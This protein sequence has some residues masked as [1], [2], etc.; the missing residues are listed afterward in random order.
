MFWLLLSSTCTDLRF[1][2]PSLPQ[3][4]WGFARSWEGTAD[5]NQ[6]KGYSIP[7][8]IMLSNKN[9]EKRGEREVIH[10][11]SICLVKVTVVHADALQYR[12]WLNIFPL[13]GHSE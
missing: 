2:T 13:M 9:L 5:S 3:V 4:G 7:Y 11:Y 12:N 1:S 8:D 10:G 6:I